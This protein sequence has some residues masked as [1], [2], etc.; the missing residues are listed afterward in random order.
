MLSIAKHIFLVSFIRN[1]Y[2]FF[3]NVNLLL[4]QSISGKKLKERVTDTDHF[5]VQFLVYITF[6]D[7][8]FKLGQ[9]VNQSDAN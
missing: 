2:L 7:W 9:R 1:V 8:L 6:C 3:F 5:S 4:K